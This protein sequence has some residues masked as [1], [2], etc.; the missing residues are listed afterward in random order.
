M[1][2]AFATPEF[3]TERN[4]SGGLANY[5]FRIGQSLQERGHR[6]H[7]FTLSYEDT[8]DFFYKGLTVHRVRRHDLK[9]LRGLTAQ[10]LQDLPER[11]ADSVALS[12]RIRKCHQQAAFDI[13]QI[14]SYYLYLGYLLPWLIR[15]VPL[16]LRIS[17]YTPAWNAIDAPHRARLRH[18]IEWLETQQ[19]RRSEQVFA[20]S[21]TLQNLIAHETGRQQITL[22]RSPFYM[23]TV[24]CDTGFYDEH[25]AGKA[26]LLYFGRLARHKGVH[27]LA[28]AVPYLLSRFPEAHVVFLGAKV[29]SQDAIQALLQQA[30]AVFPERV[31]VF[32]ALEHPKLYPVIQGARIVV[33]PSLIDNMPNACL[34]AMAFGKAIVG[35]YGSSLDEL[36]VDGETGFLVEQNNVSALT[37]AL[38][39]AWMCSNR[40]EIGRSAAAAVEQWRPEIVTKDLLLYY[41]RVIDKNKRRG[42][43]RNAQN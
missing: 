33:M 32:S 18:F 38:I 19:I 36:L 43:K 13:I 34:E 29:H 11:I 31:H 39:R 42:H 9:L 14:P 37:E 12:L 41:Q 40:A 10:R 26:Y 23:D 21:A 3:V 27:I 6:V 20:P 7:V 25:L 8:E 30:R 15:G 35:T 4:F 1:R 16:V 5:I 2:I 28:Q 17:S 24:D 22:I